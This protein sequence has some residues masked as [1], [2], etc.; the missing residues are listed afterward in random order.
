[1]KRMIRTLCAV[2]IAFFAIPQ[3]ADAQF[4]KKL[5]KAAE[6]VVKETITGE[7][8]T[9]STANST[10]ATAG[11]AEVATNFVTSASGVEVGNPGSE[12]FDLEFV[13]AVGNAASNEVTIYVKATAKKLNY[14]NAAIGGNDGR[15]TDADGNEYKTGYYP[16]KKNMMVGVPVKFEFAKFMKVPATVDKFVIVTAGWYLDTEARCP[17]GT[18]WMQY[19]IKLKNVPI[20]WE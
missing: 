16:E 7:T 3:Q 10:T 18:N 4:F 1:M 15:A 6:N 11:T 8:T 14:Q 19:A 12:H 2:A 5:K 20:K 9:E 17:G 13:E